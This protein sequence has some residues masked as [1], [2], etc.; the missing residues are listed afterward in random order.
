MAHSIEPLE[1]SLLLSHYGPY[2]SYPVPIAGNEF[3]TTLPFNPSDVPP[4]V[5]SRFFTQDLSSRKTLPPGARVIRSARDTSSTRGS[6][7][8]LEL[9][10]L[11]LST[12]GIFAMI[13][14]LIDINNLHLDHWQFNVPPNVV[15]SVLAA[16]IRAT[17]GFAISS[18][19]CAWSQFTTL[20]ICSEC[21]NVTTHM[22]RFKIN[23]TNLGTFSESA[24]PFMGE[25]T[26]TSLPYLNHTN[27]SGGTFQDSDIPDRAAISAIGRTNPGSTISFQIYSTMITTLGVLKA[28]D[29]FVKRNLT[30]DNTTVTATE[31]ILYFSTTAYNSS[32]QAGELEETE[33][34][35]WADPDFTS[36]NGTDT[37]LSQ[38]NKWNNYSLFSDGDDQRGDLTPVGSTVNYVND[39]FLA[40]PTMMAWPLDAQSTAGEPL[41]ISGLWESTSLETTFSIVA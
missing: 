17:L 18:S 2:W 35:T 16:L 20:A 34:G 4:Q 39:V 38:F 23:G 1:Q 32:L 6:T 7:W 15:V 9:V 41:V 12:A 36:Y 33:I 27:Y 30:W 26:V 11:A 5:Q 10:L 14:L 31:C 13:I 8:H 37:D 19:N 25:W 3:V 21:K 28:A 40:I 29:E 22:K 24:I